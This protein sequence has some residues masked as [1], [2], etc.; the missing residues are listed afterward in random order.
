MQIEF[1]KKLDPVPI[2][3]SFNKKP[4]KRLPK[5]K[6]IR[7]HT[8]KSLDSCVCAIMGLNEFVGAKNVR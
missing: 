6:K 5:L 2:K 1:P 7:T 4:L 3:N 8:I